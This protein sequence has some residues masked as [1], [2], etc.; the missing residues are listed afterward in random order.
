MITSIKNTNADQYS[1]LF[2]KA[3]KALMS[4]NIDGEPISQPTPNSQ[5]PAIPYK[6]IS[7]DSYEPN[8]YYYWDAEA[9]EFVLAAELEADENK[10]YY[11]LQNDAEYIAS[12]NEYFSYIKT[13]ALIDKKFTMLA[14]DEPTFDIDLN[15][16]EITVPEVFQ[17][18]GV[19][20]E[21]DEIAEII[22][23]KVN[24]YYDMTDLGDSETQIY[25]QWRS[26][27]TDENGE[28]IEGVS[29]PWSID[30]ESQPGYVIF[31]W[32]ISSKITAEAGQIAFAV[33]FYKYDE[34][35][36]SNPLTYSLS[37]LTQV[38]TVKPALNFNLV[39]R[40]LSDGPQ[41]GFVNDNSINLILARLINSDNNEGAEPASEAI[42]LK[43]LQQGS[44]EVVDDKTICWLDK[45]RDNYRIV[46][47]ILQVQAISP[48]AGRL[49]YSANKYKLDGTPLNCISKNDYIKSQDTER[50]ALKD[51]YISR[52]DGLAYE[53]ITDFSDIDW[54]E[55]PENR[56]LWEHVFSVTIDT[57]GKYRVKVT[58]KVGHNSASTFSYELTVLEPQSI[59]I[60]QPIGG[61]LGCTM[62]VTAEAGDSD[63]S[64]ITYQWRKIGL[65]KQGEYEDIPN[66]NGNSYTVPV[67]DPEDPNYDPNEGTGYYEVEAF[68][69][70][71]VNYDGT[72]AVK[73][74]VC[75][76]PVRVTRPAQACTITNLTDTQIPR[77][78]LE[79]F[80]IEATTDPSE[81]REN[82]LGDDILYQWYDYNIANGHDFNQDREDAASGIYQTVEGVDLPIPGA[83][84]SVFIPQE[85]Q[86]GTFYC[87]VTNV[88]NG[89]RAEKNSM[90]FT[91]VD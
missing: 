9:N 39:D 5:E 86:E 38:V 18:N 24:R 51:Y 79:K 2:S 3:V 73:S 71:H 60:S 57:I 41:D 63:K 15:T 76:T 61:Q 14:L 26:A 89:S 81:I 42:F 84:R 85:G 35:F 13:L 52:G 66:A 55:D 67:P 30:Y 77:Q 28:Y 8:L 7:A 82:D 21:G 70:L 17:K 83:T 54:E 64:K 40:I 16:R 87:K 32:P 20:V 78:I 1:I 62:S 36:L 59:T 11:G 90:F 31:G 69:Y 50:V 25:I 45:D 72:K 56:N 88:Y 4:H 47:V 29:V 37:T 23:F 43:N 22:Y 48:D 27:A 58:N 19:S 65:D 91:I 74:A 46:P 6:V 12:L 75:Q 49:S 33:R 34:T 80:E 44:N 10:V 68:N 53:P